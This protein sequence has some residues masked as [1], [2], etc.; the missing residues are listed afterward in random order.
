[1][2]G[3]VQGVGFRPFVFT[4]AAKH[5]LTGIVRN[6]GSQVEIEIEGDTA[7]LDAFV[8][9]LRG[10]APPLAAIAQIDVTPSVL[11]GYAGFRIV[12]S[13][14]DGGH[15]PVPPDIATCDDC[16][17]EL[18]DP[19]DRRYHY[20]FIN[21]TNCGP[22]FT[23]IEELPYDRART[24][25]R[26]FE[27]CEACRREYQDPTNR[28]FHAQPI[29]CPVCGPRV[30]LQLT[31]SRDRTDQVTGDDVLAAAA[32]LLRAGHILAV[33]GLGGFQLACDATN[34]TAVARLRQR[35]RRF[36]KPF[37][38]MVPDLEW[39]GRLAQIDPAAA[40]LLQS[41]ER[42]I[43]L[44][45]RR[46]SMMLAPEIA[47]GLSTIGLM[48]PYTPLHHLLLQEAG[49]PLVLTSGNLSEEPIAIAN[50]EA[51]QRL[52][53]VADVFLLHDRGICARYDD[54]VMRVI[55]NH[56]VPIR[57]ARSYA[58]APMALPFT[59]QHDILALGAQQKN[60]FCL[61]H[62]NNA[63]LSQHIG[64][65]A[66]L[67]TGDHLQETLG[68]YLKL[69]RAEP[70]LIAHDLHPD[71]LTTRLAQELAGTALPR[72]AV[73]HHHAHIVSCMAEHGLQGPVIGVAYDGTG[74]GADGA[75]WGGEVMTATWGG[76]ERRAH[77]RYVPLLGG[78]AAVREPLRMLA[79][80]LWSA[81]H[82]AEVAY[83]DVFRRLS[84]QQ[85]RIWHQQ[86]EEG[87][88]AP[89]TSSCGRLFDAVAVLLGVCE[90][91][92]YEGEPAARLEA[93]ADPHAQGC[94]PFEIQTGES[95]PMV[96]LSLTFAALYAGLR[97]AEPVSALATRFHNTVA[98]F[99]AQL[100]HHARAVTGINRVCLSGGCFQNALLAQRTVAALEYDRFEVFTHARVPPND[101]GI[102][103]GQAVAA[104]ARSIR[105]PFCAGS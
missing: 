8:I 6:T 102:A 60:T 88:N 5:G 29:A 32:R 63:Y 58:P 34:P 55:H 51:L 53:H 41:R 28:R 11:T 71:Y 62:G 22:R 65:L 43:V 39:A 44:L 73:Q 98:A 82:N 10:H 54:S 75:V 59:A 3:I 40:A 26:E 48:L 12:Q 27:M 23:I 61:V 83:A 78:E 50:Q 72:V 49:G 99:T 81:H 1:V 70:G 90:E 9:D 93:A 84:A 13:E 42:P 101:G 25:M 20:P 97:R 21:C 89:P 52:E 91:A 18:F 38:L 77:L 15:Q 104:H 80:H 66:Q 74:L 14:L 69:Y 87:V 68:L 17:R 36:G 100:C 2:R 94:L 7:S 96:D 19:G 35:K 103:L 30:W 64:E 24:T 85:R 31:S 33:K 76:Y 46:S 56:A 67:S 92:R 86:F 79:S 16:L 47:S 95:G 37:A 45:E 4:L 57:R 105:S